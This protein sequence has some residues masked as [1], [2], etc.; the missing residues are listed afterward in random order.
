M[1][2][3]A[4]SDGTQAA[5]DVG[6]EVEQVKLPV[7]GKDTLDELGTNAE[8]ECADPNGEVYCTASRGLEHPVED[9]RDNEEGDQVEE[10][11]VG[12]ELL[13]D[14]RRGTVRQ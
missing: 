7:I 2:P 1:V 9:Q 8:S 5:D 13:W 6:N 3:P 12:L 14:I 4:Q 10:F 11:I